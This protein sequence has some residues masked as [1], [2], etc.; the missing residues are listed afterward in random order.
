MSEPAYTS[1]ALDFLRD[2]AAAMGKTFDHPQGG[3]ALVV[4]E[5]YQML[6]LPPVDPLLGKIN[7][8]VETIDD[9]S[10]SAYVNRFKASHPEALIFA[11]QR[12]FH[13]LAV[14][15][16]HAADG[17]ADYARHR[18]SFKPMFD[19]S[20]ARWRDIDGKSLAQDVFAGFVE[21]N[22]Q[23]IVSPDGAVFLDLISNLQAKRDVSF[24][25]GVKLQNG[26]VQVTYA[27]TTEASGLGEMTFPSDFSIGLP[28]FFGT[29]GFRMRCLLRY[30]IEERKLKFIVKIHRRVM[31]EQEAFAE[32][33]KAIAAATGVPVILGTI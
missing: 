21:E 5:G 11:D 32:I 18:V 10:F 19:E 14:L 16:Y 4:P 33:T 15:D 22:I 9:A 7:Q 28:V 3:E 13:H 29:Q 20:Y 26:S 23:D 2:S 6:Y 24:K 27:E 30:R 25:S 1:H 12:K 31:A 17:N 8:N